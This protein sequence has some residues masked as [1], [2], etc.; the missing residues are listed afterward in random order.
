M[1]FFPKT[2]QAYLII[3][4]LVK[5]EDISLLDQKGDVPYDFPHFY[6]DFEGSNGPFAAF[7]EQ[8]KVGEITIKMDASWDRI[9]VFPKK[10]T[11]PSLGRVRSKNPLSLDPGTLK[12][13]KDYYDREVALY[14]LGQKYK[15]LKVRDIVPLVESGDGNDQIFIQ[16]TCHYEM[17]IKDYFAKYRDNFFVKQSVQRQL[18]SDKIE[19]SE[20]AIINIYEFKRIHTWQFEK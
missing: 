5:F 17:T 18:G 2:N 9:S 19:G 6:V 16:I 20:E 1:G 4:G 11:K 7:W 13:V 3:D 8:F 14:D 12:S 10:F 15:F